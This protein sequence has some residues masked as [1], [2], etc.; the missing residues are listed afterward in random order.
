[1][2]L[3]TD[4]ESN[5]GTIDPLAAAKA[6]QAYGIKIYAVAMSDEGLIARPSSGFFGAATALTNQSITAE[7][8]AL[9]M[10]IAK[11]TGADF[12]RAKNN[13]E[14]QEIYG[15]INALEKTEFKETSQI[16]YKDRYMPFLIAALLLLLAAFVLDKFIFIKVP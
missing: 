11:M 4:G 3:L 5:S 10:E 1:M 9:L 6:A 8:Q 12:Y 16:N 15:V 2:I 14:L 7:G 13:L